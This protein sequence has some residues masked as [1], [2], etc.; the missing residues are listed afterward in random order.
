MSASLIGRAAE[1]LRAGRNLR[2]V[3]RAR[4]VVPD[5]SE[6][7]RARFLIEDALNTADFGDCGRLIVIRRLRL[8]RLPP[9][10]SSHSVALALERAWRDAAPRAVAFDDARAPEAEI[11]HAPDAETARAALLERL[12]RGA[13]TGAWFWPRLVPEFEPGAAPGANAPRLIAAALGDTPAWRALA[14]EILRWPETRIVALVRLLP[15]EAPPGAVFEPLKSAVLAQRATPASRSDPGAR[16]QAPDSPVPSHAAAPGAAGM[17]AAAALA[18]RLLPG[19]AWAREFSIPATDWRL[20]LLAHAAWTAAHHLPP[21]APEL[22]AVARAWEARASG[23]APTPRSGPEPRPPSPAPESQEPRAAGERAP[24]ISLASGLPETT[25][26]AEG[27][28]AGGAVPVAAPRIPGAAGVPWLAD[29]RR[30]D[31]GGLLMALNM[32]Q[33]LGFDHWLA[34]QAPEL[35]RPLAAALLSGLADRAGVAA[36]DPQRELFPADEDEQARVLEADCRW[37]GHPW[38]AWLRWAAPGSGQDGARALRAW[39]AAL[40]RGLRISAGLSLRR[41]IRRR[42]WVSATPTH[43]DVVFPLADADLALRRAGLDANPGW[44]P[45]FGR[46]VAFHYLELPG[47][48]GDA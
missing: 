14:A 43:V 17:P 5:A 35:R 38:P 2:L 45:W 23:T 29:A 30:T 42:G 32:L 41:V 19:P 13:D 3:A 6:Q 22:A 11:V 1:A 46:I 24:S 15:T 25:H 26:R 12:L 28:E 39:S 8:P 21:G 47:E 34:I 36:D 10:A 9:Q 27:I 7:A 37:A 48:P 4:L 31:S 20:M 18:A 16:A 40:R 33:N 44:V